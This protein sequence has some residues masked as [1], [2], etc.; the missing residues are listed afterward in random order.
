MKRILN[1]HIILV[2][3]FSLASSKTADRIAVA[4][5][6]QGEVEYERGDEGFKK[7]T[8]G[9]ILQGGD[10]VRTGK[11]GFTAII[12]IDDKSMLKI[13]EKTEVM[14]KGQ[15]SQGSI[16]KKI[17]LDGGTLR[18]QVTPQRKGDFVVQTPV[19]VASVKGTDF[20][21]L[22]NDQTGDQL[23]GIDGIV[24]L[25]NLISGDSIDVSAGFTGLSS[26]D[27][28][29]QSFTTDPT[30]IPTDPAGA[31]TEQPSRLEIEFKSPDGKTKTL[32]INYK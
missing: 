11:N 13:K 2:I 21:L 7:L 1:I 18:A 8:A 31:E 6:V 12:F 28:S 19:S 26:L 30:T 10:R 5:K 3:F 4:T 16:S 32:I 20:W 9:N 17:H 22:S 14:I 29:I 25:V 23:I 24:A 27:G 15:R